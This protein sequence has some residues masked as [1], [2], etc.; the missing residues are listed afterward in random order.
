[1]PLKSFLARITP[2]RWGGGGGSVDNTLPG[3]GGSIDNTLPGE[4]GPVD[5]GYGIEA[6]R[7]S[8]PIVIPP[9]PGIWPPAGRPSLP[10]Y[11]PDNGDS[12]QLPIYIE[13]TPEH[14]ITQPPGSFIPPLPDNSLPG[15]KPVVVL[16]RVYGVGS[17]WFVYQPPTAQPK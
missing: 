5:P 1:M 15:E 6:G 7:P 12:V 16:V 4:E 14:P 3:E 17:R 10:I 8:H 11:L 9:L 13:G 2:V